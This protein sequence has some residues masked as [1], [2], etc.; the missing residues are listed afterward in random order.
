MDGRPGKSTPADRKRRNTNGIATDRRGLGTV[1][2]WRIFD[3]T[4]ASLDKSGSIRPE[5]AGNV[6]R[7]QGGR[8]LR[9][10]DQKNASTKSVTFALPHSRDGFPHLCEETVK[11]TLKTL[12]QQNEIDVLP[13]LRDE[14]A[15]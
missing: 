1:H 9:I 8:D 6:Q 3:L 15:A 5:R 10:S 13:S 11:S 7:G 2:I 14:T 12:E 4:E